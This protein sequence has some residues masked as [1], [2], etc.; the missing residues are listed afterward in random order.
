MSWRHLGETFD[1]HAGGIDLVFPHH[2]NEIA[3]SRCCFGTLVMANVWL[4]NGFLQVEG[5]KMAKSAGNFVTIHELLGDFFGTVLRY[6]MLRTHYRQ[7]IDW[8]RDELERSRHE[9]WKWSDIIIDK[10][11]EAELMNPKRDLVDAGVIDALMD[12]LNTPNALAQLHGLADAAKTDREAARRFAATVG[13]FGLKGLDVQA[14]FT[15]SFVSYVP[16]ERMSVYFAAHGDLIRYKNYAAN[17]AFSTADEYKERVRMRGIEPTITDDEL[18]IQFAGIVQEPVNQKIDR[19][20]ADRAAA[21]AAKNW[22]ESDRIRDELKAIGIV[23][24]D[25]KDGTTTW[26]VAR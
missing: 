11:V 13:F 2:E 15:D 24:H 8:R 9:L 5:E 10:A 21:R 18:N 1:I 23:L 6:N 17:G 19:L 25:N 14:N 7:P 4:H 22:K 20:I 12:D 16:D 3:Q 26:E